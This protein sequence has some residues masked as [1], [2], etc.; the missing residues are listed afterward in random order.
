[1]VM[2]DV[3][4]QTVQHAVQANETRRVSAMEVDFVRKQTHTTRET[5]DVL[6]DFGAGYGEKLFAVK[7][8]S[9][10]EN[11]GDDQQEPSPRSWHD[12]TRTPLPYAPN[13]KIYCLYG[14]GIETERAYYYR[15]NVVNDGNHSVLEQPGLILDPTVQQPSEGITSG[16]RY[17]DGDGSVP[18]ISLGYICADAWQRES[19]GLNPSGAKVYTRE[20]KHHAEFMVDDPVRSGPK[21]ADHVDFLGNEDMMMDLARI[22][23]DFQ[24]EK[25]EQ[26]H[27][28]SDIEQIAADINKRGGIFKKK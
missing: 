19:S 7:D 27:I 20:Y 2:S 8:Y 1:M 5:I 28:V 23:S 4:N 6:K 3:H 16:I 11:D 21:S 18:L 17:T 12:P 13:L 25:V 15:R 10:H 24:V 14:I 26:N 9:Y 22:V